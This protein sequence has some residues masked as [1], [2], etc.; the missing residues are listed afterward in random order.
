MLNTNPITEQIL[1]VYFSAAELQI[2]GRG[3]ATAIYGTDAHYSCA[4]DDSTGAFLFCF[5]FV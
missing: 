3:D 2:T 1:F 4:I 5:V